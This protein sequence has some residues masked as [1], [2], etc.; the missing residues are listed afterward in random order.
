MQPAE[1]LQR[2]DQVIQNRFGSILADVMRQF[3]GAELGGL[4]C[5]TS[6]GCINRRSGL[7]KLPLKMGSGR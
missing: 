2:G 4:V 5:F 6:C 1:L 3:P 7:A